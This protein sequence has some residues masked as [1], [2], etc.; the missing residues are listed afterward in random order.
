M[1]E[2]EF[3]RALF[4]EVYS[5]LLAIH[6]GQVRSLRQQ[7]NAGILEERQ[8]LR[9]SVAK[10]GSSVLADGWLAG[11]RL[12]KEEADFFF[13]CGVM[14][15]LMDDL[16]DLPEDRAAGHCTLFTR[17]AKAEPLDRLT[18][19]LWAFMHGV[20]N[21]T[22]CFTNPRGLE[23][24]DLIRSNSIMLMLRAIAE[25]AGLFS[26][27]YLNHMERLSPLSFSFLRERGKE[28]KTRFE[29]IWPALSRRRK[30]QSIFDLMG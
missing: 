16:Q 13:G 12:E 3:P 19:R 20:L 30:L 5:S 25:S 4:P 9:I 10:G 21:S 28:V 27:E 29:K 26:A 23:L 1:I 7:N 24:R 6:A 18:N 14:L 8:L 2:D 15:Q 11:G 17:A 22:A